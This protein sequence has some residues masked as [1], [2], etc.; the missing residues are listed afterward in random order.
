[1]TLLTVKRI[2]IV[3]DETLVAFH[4]EDILLEM[5]HAV[6]GPAVRLA[7]AVLLARDGEFDFAIVD[8]NLAGTPS[9]AVADILRAR[10]IPFVFVT[11]YGAEGIAAS[12]GSEPTLRKPYTLEALEQAVTSGLASVAK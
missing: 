4:L 10:G 11:G 2:L 12:Y 6:I 8:M 7:D 1:M 9:L 3:E 5:G